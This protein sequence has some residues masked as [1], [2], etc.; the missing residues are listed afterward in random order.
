M[1]FMSRAHL[2][3]RVADAAG[4]AANRANLWRTCD[5]A[6]GLQRPGAGD[7][8]GQPFRDLRSPN[9][10]CGLPQ[11]IESLGNIS[12]AD[13]IVA[14][15]VASSFATDSIAGSIRNARRGLRSHG[16]SSDRR[17]LSP[18]SLTT[19]A[20]VLPTMRE[21]LRPTSTAGSQHSEGVRCNIPDEREMQVLQSEMVGS[22]CPC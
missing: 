20:R 16:R 12:H 11:S 7:A 10:L 6:W 14:K 15:R 9:P 21:T 5:Q 3:M 1:L 17:N 2:F 22:I 13:S 8:V 19:G 18:A 4:M